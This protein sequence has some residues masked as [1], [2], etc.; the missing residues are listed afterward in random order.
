VNHGDEASLQIVWSLF[1]LEYPM[2]SQDD[3]D[4]ANVISARSDAGGGTRMPVHPDVGQKS[5]LQFSVTPVIPKSIN[6]N[7]FDF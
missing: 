1:W 3:R 6:G 5:N 4:S 2:P 7:L